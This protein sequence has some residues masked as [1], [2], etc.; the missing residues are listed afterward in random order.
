MDNEN[1]DIDHIEEYEFDRFYLTI[2]V[3]D[4][5]LELLP[6]G[7]LPAQK[8]LKF[9]GT[10]NSEKLPMS[11]DM[12]S[13]AAKD[14]VAAKNELEFVSF[15]ELLVAIDVWM[16]ESSRHYDRIKP[17]LRNDHPPKRRRKV[18]KK[19]LPE[20]KIDDSPKKL[21]GVE[22]TIQE[23]SD[24]LEES[25]KVHGKK[26]STDETLATLIDQAVEYISTMKNYKEFSKERVVQETA[27]WFVRK[28]KEEY[29]IALDML[30][31]KTV[32]G[33]YYPIVDGK[34]ARRLKF[35][36]EEAFQEEDPETDE[37]I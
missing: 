9:L 36:E 37:E 26:D 15:N 10:Q 13:L 6:L 17:T 14:P 16:E 11:L 3:G 4:I 33:N 21:E 18:V 34:I 35:T 29:L 28:G 31:K 7:E 2:N 19:E 23:I 22:R 32:T 27:K 8:V 20:P 30:T 25:K 5:E 12:F 1:I 24:E